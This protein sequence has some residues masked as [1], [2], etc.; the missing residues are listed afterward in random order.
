MS[1]AICLVGNRSIAVQLVIR[2]ILSI[3]K[4]NVQY[5][6]TF[7]LKVKGSHATTTRRFRERIFG[8]L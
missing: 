2:K 8:S 5:Y 4:R 6:N 3:R 1:L 7:L